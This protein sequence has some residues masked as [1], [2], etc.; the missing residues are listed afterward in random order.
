VRLSGCEKRVFR[1]NDVGH[2]ED[3]LIASGPD[4]PKL[5]VFESVYSMDGDV[6]PVRAICDLA[7]RY[8]AMTY[9][10]EVH[11]VGMYG[12]RGGGIAEREGVMARVDVVEGTLAKAFGCL[13]GYIAG[14]A[15]LIDAVRSY[16]PGFIFTTALPPAI[17]AAA[18]AAIRHLK[19][20]SWERTRHQQNVDRTK[21]VLGAAGLPVMPSATHIVPLRVGD[22]E[23]CKKASD[24]LLGEHGI[25]I[26]P[27]NYPTVPRGTERLRITPTPFHE[28]ALIDLLAKALVEVW[29]Q[30]GL[31]LQK[32][33]TA[34]E[35]PSRT[36]N[37]RATSITSTR[38]KNRLHLY[39]GSS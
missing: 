36:P 5:I 7:D 10:D 16:A 8:G 32:S 20:S 30:L 2:L 21:A 24:L 15:D 31:P 6:A 17:C 37:A 38:G 28:G 12:E 29:S 13:G 22:P 34:A 35:S 1:H 39:N 33:A 27:I 18:S 14:T 3:L 9:L 4:R 11:A 26:Q 19:T 23:K 25:Y